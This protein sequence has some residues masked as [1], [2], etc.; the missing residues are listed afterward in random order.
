MAGGLAGANSD[1][2]PG[3]VVNCFWDTVTSGLDT[4]EG[5]TGKTTEEMQ[6]MW[7]Y[8]NTGWD[9]EGEKANGSYD[10]WKM[11]CGRPIYP[12]L[13]WEQMLMGDFVEPEGVDVLDIEFLLDHWLQTVELPCKSPDLTVDA[14][15]DVKDFEL[16]AQYWGRGSREVIFE[17]TLDETADFITQGQWQFGVPTGLGGG[18]YGHPDP[19]TGYTGDNVYGV[20]LQGDYPMDVDGPHYLIAGPFDCSVYRD[21]KLQFA[22]WLNTDESD[23]VSATIEFS[24]DGTR[25]VPVWE[26]EDSEDGHTDDT[27]Y[28]VTYNLGVMADYRESLYIRWGY[29]IKNV[30]A[31]PMSGWNIDDIII[32]AVR[33]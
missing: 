17:T 3:E 2:H 29:E 26:H 18:E 19:S 30:E 16:M 5:G 8:F 15:I 4:S 21:V 9:F 10:I 25:W 7:M 14:R 24:T 20:N 22:R 28:V 13:A 27:W 12:K 11:C 31:W 33:W 32:S 23:Y 6:D 1:R